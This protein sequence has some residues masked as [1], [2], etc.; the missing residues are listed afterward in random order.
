MVINRN[1]PTTKTIKPI[2]VKI[3]EKWLISPDERLIEEFATNAPM[4]ISITPNIFS[5]TNKPIG[6]FSLILEPLSLTLQSQD[7][8]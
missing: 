6:K 3:P 1:T 5:D 7:L 4:I 2:N 8:F